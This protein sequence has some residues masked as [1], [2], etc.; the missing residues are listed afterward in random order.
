MMSQFT[1]AAVAV[2]VLVADGDGL[3]DAPSAAWFTVVEWLPPVT[4]ITIPRVR[5]IAAGMASVTATRVARF[6]P[7]R[8]RADR[9]PMGIGSPPYSFAPGGI[10]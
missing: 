2:V 9:C 7:R 5:P 1:F 8:R 4:A 10:R 6:G 3:A